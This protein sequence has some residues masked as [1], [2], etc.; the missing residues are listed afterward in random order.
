M[1]DMG[2]NR[3]DDKYFVLGVVI[4]GQGIFITPVVFYEKYTFAYK[5]ALVTLTAY[6]VVF[7]FIIMV[8]VMS[9]RFAMMWAWL[10]FDRL[11][12]YA[13]VI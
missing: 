3:L 4:M 5:S 11:D 10:W 6:D 12:Q 1:I 2:S 8:S 9:S 13:T 7:S